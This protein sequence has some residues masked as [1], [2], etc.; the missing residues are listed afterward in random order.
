MAR[1]FSRKSHRKRENRGHSFRKRSGRR[2]STVT[3]PERLPASVRAGIWL[4]IAIALLPTWTDPDLWGH[5]RFGLDFFRYHQLPRIDPYSFTQ[6]RPWIN[7]EWLSDALSAAA[8]ASPG[9]LRLAVLK[10]AVRGRPR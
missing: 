3:E 10:A 8:Y 7:H 1:S 6:D 9:T 4:L 2:C 5:V